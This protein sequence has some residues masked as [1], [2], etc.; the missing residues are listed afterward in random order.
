MRTLHLVSHT[1]WDREW[2]QTFQQF[3]L[4]LVRLVDHLLEIL[5]SDPNYVHFMLDGQMIV[6]EDYLAIRPEREP[7]LRAHVQ[8]G[9][10]E[11]G[12]WYILPDEF[13]VSPEA[14]VRNLLEG[15]RVARRFGQKMMV[16][17]E[18]DAF[19]HIGQ[20][21]QILRGFGIQNAAV[22]RGLGNQ[23]CEFW[24]QSP[25]GSRVLM[26]YM[27]LGYGNAA[28]ILDSSL[29]LF[30]RDAAKLRA[31]MAK[32]AAAPHLLFMHGVDHMEPQAQTSAAVAYAAGQLDGDRLLHSTL[33][34]YFNGLR[35]TLDLGALPVYHGEMRASKRHPLLPGVLST[36]MWIKQRNRAC[37]TLLEKWAE[38]F[39]AWAAWAAGGEPES[40]LL[41]RS[42][43]ILRQAWRLL[44]QCHP[45]DSI[46]GCSIDQVHEEMRPRFD[47]VEQIGEEIT[48]QALASL[49]GRV[50]TLPPGGVEGVTAS[51]VVFNPTDLPLTELVETVLETPSAHHEVELVDDAG[52]SV[53]F[54]VMGS[55]SQTIFNMV[56]N[57][58]EFSDSMGM[59]SGGVIMHWK[60]VGLE[61]SSEG[62]QVTVEMVLSEQASP[63]LAAWERGSRAIEEFLKDPALTVFNIRARS[64][65]E[66][67]VTFSAADVPGHG[68][69]TFWVREK[70]AAP[71]VAMKL[72]PLAG[73]LMPLARKLAANPAAQA[74]IERLMP[75]ASRKPPF[76]IE[77]EFFQV[78]AQP[79]GTLD[80][81]DKRSG[82][83]YRGQNRLVDG[84]D[85]GDEYNYS[86]P[87]RDA[88]AA[89]RFKSARV[90]RG[91]ARQTLELALEL[92]VSEG[93][94]PD[95]Q[96]RAGKM[97]TL[98]VTCRVTLARGVP[99]VD[100]HTEIDNRAR[101][102]RL[103]VHF[104][105]PFALAPGARA[106]YDGHY[107][108]IRR[109]L[110]L[111]AFDAQW[112][113]QP[114]PETSQRAFSAIDDGRAG[115][116]IA[117]RGLPEAQAL[118][119]ADG[120]GEIAVTL[121]R[122]VGWL[123][124][125]DF[126]ERNGHAG[127]FMATPGAQMPGVWGFDYSIVPFAVEDTLAAYHQA[128]AFQAGLRAASATLHEGK[129]PPQGRLLSVEPAAFAVSAVKITEDGKG[130]IVRGAN[131]TSGEV[132]AAVRPLL[133]YQRAARANL[134]EE[135]Q[136]AVEPGE[137][138]ALTFTA[139]PCEV[140]TLRFE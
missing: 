51:V 13:L 3:R 21:P 133:P 17:Y 107:E 71:Q 34:A 75:D 10:V 64:A 47:Q 60:V 79:D 1:H 24:W 22:M 134:A 76:K 127:P 2:Y 78:E 61:V 6:L 111:P 77:N 56:M 16:G 48:R 67:R 14:T 65:E 131:L 126:P 72:S 55:G 28:G 109:P 115:L 23:P 118:R 4:R 9:R 140:V 124:R 114:R 41:A 89:A 54:E 45:H 38:P 46:C 49:V 129:L 59:V 58:H 27:P 100:I 35:E 92:L 25:D 82:R 93:L 98:P 106:A 94:A 90:E 105:A 29:D 136:A 81:L 52:A 31:A 135:I 68:Y 83:V 30:V 12:P 103:R 32:E 121:L 113:E 110:D 20:L 74:W 18:P 11:V 116:L 40:V 101:D 15:D 97:V 44:M 85:R 26:G 70:A 122:C 125:D 96:S 130:W 108:V 8:S 37:E 112:V 119:G 5:D 42:E 62:D 87:A 53:P 139:R 7:E 104:P 91:A 128:Y 88:L 132:R 86:P 57:R 69:R 66:L 80:V 19:G 137:G 50:R 63:N 138:A 95:R 84:G 99:R 33:E 102:H 36:R 43:E 73:M 123:S 120:N 39:S 117:N